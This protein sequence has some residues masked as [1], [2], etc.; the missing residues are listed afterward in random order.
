MT[1]LLLECR[2]PDL[3]PPYDQALYQA[4]TFIL[5]R[6]D[7][8]GIIA[9]GS[10]IRGTPNPGSDLDI[11]VINTQSQR[12]RIQKFFQ[13]VPAE[14][15]VNPVAA[16]ERYFQEESE[17]GR[18]CTAHMFV[19]GFVVLDR[20][21]IVEQLRRQAQRFLERPPNPSDTHLTWLRYGAADLYENA[22]DI[23]ETN[24]V[25]ANMILSRAVFHMLQYA[26]W[27]ANQYLPRDKD[28]LEAITDLD[29]VLANL[30]HDFY[31]SADPRQCQAL[32]AK[33]ADR[34]IEVDGFFEWESVPENVL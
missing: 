23:A 16:I 15:F 18:P 20:D 34:T 25:G 11:F 9:A 26:F 10:I 24:P 1:N 29:P 27:K 2:W 17:R 12:Q 7:V 8:L 33:I 5:N 31:T 13:A 21:P 14:I 6:F 30:A 19:T 4:V 32:A 28:L 22:R 3:S